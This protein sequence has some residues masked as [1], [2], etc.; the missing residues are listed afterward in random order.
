MLSVAV[1]TTAALASVIQTQIN[2][3]ELSAL[4]A[5]VGAGT[6]IATTLEDL[7][8]FGPV[9]VGITAA[10]FLLSLTAGHVVSRR[11]SARLRSV[12]LALAGAAGLWTAFWLLGKVSPMPALVE[13]TDSV[14]GLAAVCL[15]GLPGGALYARMTAAGAGRQPARGRLRAVLP[16]AAL[17]LV[18]ALLFYA[19]APRPG[20]AV[21][22]TFARA[23]PTS[24]RVQTIA[25]GLQRPWS[26]AFLPDGRT[27][28]TEREGRLL[29]LGR[30]G[31]VAAIALDGLPPVPRA[32][33]GPLMNIVV[34]PDF[35]QNRLLY[36]TMGYGGPGA[37]GTRLLRA[38]LAGDRLEDVRVLLSSTLKSS[39]GNNGG[40]LAVLADGTLVMSVGD[41]H[42]REQAQVPGRCNAAGAPWHNP[43]PRR[44]C[45]R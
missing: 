39:P 45:V 30:D 31:K 23:D 38:R 21:A 20:A 32:G 18:P 37:N 36:L 43:E 42:R 16:L 41:G 10:A 4:G 28:V 27:L 5:P 25:V 7:A 33:G 11:M 24:Y 15:S 22:V 17:V 3:A 13:A 2:L 1:L 8:R 14:G 34:D 44:G 19:M 40:A 9:T 29:A 12:V 35:T 26:V 6:R